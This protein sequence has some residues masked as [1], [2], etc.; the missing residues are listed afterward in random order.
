VETRRA[1]A[2]SGTA[3]VSPVSPAAV[4]ETHS[5]VVCMVGDRAYKLKKPVDLGFVNFRDRST[6][7]AVCARD[8]RRVVG[9]VSMRD[10]L[11]ALVQ[12]VTPDTAFVMLQRVQIDAPEVWLG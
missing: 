2:G 1:F 7:A 6:R 9:A 3:C 4:R 5:G 12:T 10:A 11:T 8:N